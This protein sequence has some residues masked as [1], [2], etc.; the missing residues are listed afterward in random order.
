MLE[1]YTYAIEFNVQV[2]QAAKDEFAKN[3][4]PEDAEEIQFWVVRTQEKPVTA[5][6]DFR[7][8]PKPR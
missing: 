4:Y 7:L 3:G 8:M 1:G 6:L 2:T 5:R